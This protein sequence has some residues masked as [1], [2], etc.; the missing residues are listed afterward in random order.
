[1]AGVN[2]IPPPQP[3]TS[4]VPLIGWGDSM[5]YQLQWGSL[6]AL[7]RAQFGP[8]QAFIS[9]GV[10]GETSTQVK[11]RMLADSGT[12]NYDHVIWVGR[13]NYSQTAQIISDVAEMVAAIPHDRYM[14]LSVTNGSAA[15]ERL[16]GADHHYFTDA[17][18]ALA[19]A[20][21]VRFVDV[22][23]ALVD[24]YDSGTPQDVTDHTDDTTPS[25]CRSDAVH[26]SAKGDLVV[27]QQ[28]ISRLIAQRS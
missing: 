11:A 2:K 1:M 4:T 22:R 17:R 18:D 6:P 13:N 23:Q 3:G 25:T 9:M 28:I 19:A 12:K 21:G 26:L 20:Y 15:A 16:G 10:G 24:A 7:L 27:A 8:T 5:T 14:A